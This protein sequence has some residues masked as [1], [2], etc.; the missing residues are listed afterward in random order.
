[1]KALLS[2]KPE[3]AFQIFSGSKR[4]EYRRRIFKQPVEKVIVYV[5]SPI[6]MV[7]GEFEIE[8]LLFDNIDALW[9]RTKCASGISEEFFYQ[10]FQEREYGYAIKIGQVTRFDAPLPLE[11]T[12]GIKPPQFFVYM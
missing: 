11:E 4:F 7:L 12:Y 8:D 2:I 6:S 1:M 5:S 3:F 10:Y 9:N